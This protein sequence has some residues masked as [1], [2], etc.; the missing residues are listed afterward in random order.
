MYLKRTIFSFS[1][2]FILSSLGN[3]ILVE[4][5]VAQPQ[6][7]TEERVILYTQEWD[8]ERD[9]YGRPL[10]SD[11]IIERMKH[12]VVEEA[13]GTFRDFGY[14]NQLEVGWEILNPE[15][16][17]VGRALT[18]AFLPRRAELDDRNWQDWFD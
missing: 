13:W 12:V 16:V 8:G 15:E 5:G 11:N 3:M 4:N 7:V 1:L 14:N 2:A 10:V 6:L 9:Q 18:T 17:M